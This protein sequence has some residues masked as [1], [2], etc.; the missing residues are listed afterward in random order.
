SEQQNLILVLE[1]W[2]LEGTQRQEQIEKPQLQGKSECGRQR[3]KSD[4]GNPRD[5]LCG[6]CWDVLSSGIQLFIVTASISAL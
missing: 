2:F 5:G 3:L 1:W 4:P 6:L